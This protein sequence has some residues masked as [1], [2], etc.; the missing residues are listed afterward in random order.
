[1]TNKI[2]KSGL[3]GL[4]F[5]CILL[6]I[7]WGKEIWI[8]ET[9]EFALGAFGSAIE[10]W[11]AFVPT[12]ANLNHGQT[13]AVYMLGHWLMS[14][15]GA[16]VFWLRF[17]SLVTGGLL[18]WYVHYFFEQLKVPIRWQAWAFLALFSHQWIS[19]F[20]YE[21]RAYVMLEAAAAGAL[22]YYMTPFEM[23][24][25]MRARIVGWS[26]VLIGTIFHPYFSFYWLSAC[27]VGYLYLSMRETRRIPF[28]MHANLS[29]S[30]IGVLIYFGLGWMTWL[31]HKGPDFSQFA[32]ADPFRFIPKQWSV[33]RYMYQNHFL[34]LRWFKIPVTLLFGGVA[35]GIWIWKP[36]IRERARFFA[37]LSILACALAVS[38]VLSYISYRSHYW[39]LERQWVGSFVLCVMGTGWFFSLFEEQLPKAWGTAFAAAA[40]A[41]TVGSSVLYEARL[42]AQVREWRPWGAAKPV[43]T[44]E[45]AIKKFGDDWESLARAN[46]AAGG[47]VWP[48]FKRMYQP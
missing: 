41:F 7:Q 34:H 20:F 6:S 23:R 10:A 4:G 48:V 25:G 22:A 46:M 47:S 9:A 27:A 43:L 33:A 44:S 21:A 15:F 30:V 39:I 13:G 26:S 11:R 16:D 31:G 36:L 24:G 8:D 28:L 12:T 17:P 1:M 18:F 35:V 40:L 5:L 19:Y 38:A 29:L 3:F 2:R 37:A 45:Q 32:G 42:V 14:F